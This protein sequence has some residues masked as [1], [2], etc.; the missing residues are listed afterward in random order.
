MT[1]AL[2]RADLTGSHDPAANI[3]DFIDLKNTL[4]SRTPAERLRQEE[5]A[6]GRLKRRAG[7][8][9]GSSWRFTRTP[10]T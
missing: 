8:P 2:R 1:V 9:T 5:A 4:F 7:L 3:L 10:S 6:T